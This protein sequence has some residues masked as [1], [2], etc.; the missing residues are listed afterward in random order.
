[1]RNLLLLVVAIV[2]AHQAFADSSCEATNDNGDQSCSVS[3]PTG[4]A[5][6]CS[7]GSGSSAP[8]CECRSSGNM[9]SLRTFHVLK[10]VVEASAAVAGAAAAAPSP[11]I[12]QQTDVM[13]NVNAKLA[14]LRDHAIGQSCRSV[15]SGQYCYLRPCVHAVPHKPEATTG[16]LGV[17]PARMMCDVCQPTYA[18]ECSPVM[19]KLT[20]SEPV[21]VIG[22]P[23]VTISPPNW[24]EI[25]SRIFGYRETYRNC[26]PAEQGFTFQHAQVV[27]KGSKVTKTKTLSTTTKIDAKVSFEFFFKGETSV[28]FSQ[29]VGMNDVAEQNYQTQDTLTLTLPVRAAQMGVT[30]VDH[31]WLQRDVPVK[32]DG[33]ATLD[34]AIAANRENIATLSQ[35]FPDAV[36]RAFPFSG[37]VTATELIE[38]QTN[39]TF[40]KLSEAQ[41]TGQPRDRVIV[42]P[43]SYFQVCNGGKCTEMKPT[44]R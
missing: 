40:S 4:E 39:T 16:I 28:G 41:C 25:P 17:I 8:S 38:G 18:T 29:T 27:T 10:P 13:A 6:V 43:K 1:M 9:A 37:Y 3:C 5:A 2:F 19:G 11:S 12:V 21:R 44:I 15:E 22:D 26:T 14:S 36:A 30:T 20:A 34:T 32:F 33:I 42:E 31:W 7:K 35:V 24:Q 23:D